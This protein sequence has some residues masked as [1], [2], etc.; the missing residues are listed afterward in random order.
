MYTQK[1][2]TMNKQEYILRS[3]QKI[4]HKKW[5]L[6]IISR[7][8]HKLD[9]LDIEFVTQQLVRLHDGTRKLTDLYFPQLGFY[10]EIDEPAHDKQKEAD[11]KRSQD[12]IEA[13]DLDEK[14]IKVYHEKMEQ[15]DDSYKTLKEICSEA[16]ELISYIKD[17]KIEKEKEGCFK[18]WNFE[19]KYSSK[20]I[21]ERGELSVKEN[22]VFKFQIEALR[23][24]GFEGKSWQRGVWR[25]P[26]GTNDVV[27]FPRLYPHNE[28]WENSLI[29]EGKRI[30]E[31][32]AGNNH[33]AVQSLKKQR[34]EAAQYPDRKYIVFAKAKDPLGFNLLRYVGTFKMNLSEKSKTELIFDRIST[35]EK[36]RAI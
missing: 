23:C 20:P 5:E 14:R 2:D 29:N 1:D 21:I 8:I 25:I 11:E 27:W 15:G 7:I 18:P 22:D 33:E 16:D 10:L 13:T 6:F 26:D 9:D 17:K 24:F 12:I 35:T 31:K 4:S 19:Q 36:T 3:L 30:I 32:A 28:L 34:A